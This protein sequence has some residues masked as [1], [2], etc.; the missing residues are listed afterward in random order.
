MEEINSELKD[1]AKKTGD[2]TGRESEVKARASPDM[3]G[4][5]DIEANNYDSKIPESLHERQSTNRR[6]NPNKPGSF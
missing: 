4:D 1:E 6:N 5:Y 2:A 3:K